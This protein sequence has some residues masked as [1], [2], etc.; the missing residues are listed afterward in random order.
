MNRRL[1]FFTLIS[2]IKIAIAQQLTGLVAVT[3]TFKINLDNHYKFSA[4]TLIPDSEV[5]HLRG[6]ILT[7]E[8]YSI[9]YSSNSFALSPK[10]SYSI[11]DTIIVHYQTVKLSLKKEYKIREAK[12]YYD[13]SRS[14][15]LFSLSQSKP[16][17]TESIFGAEIQKS[18]T[19]I[20]GFTIGSNK[21]LSLQ[22]G[23]RLQLSGKLTEDIELVA[24]IS[25]E[26]SP[27]QPEGNTETLDEL[28]K[29]FIQL[30]HKNF[31]AVF[32][33]YEIKKRSGE[34]GVVN[35]R[36]QGLSGSFQ[37]DDYNG[38]VAIASSKGKFNSQKF[39]GL[40]GVQ[41][42][43]RLSGL[44]GEREIIIIAGTEKVF[45]DGEEIKRGERNDYT[46]DY[47]I[48]E[49]TFTTN[50]LI[51]AASRIAVDFEYTDRR[52]IRNFF[53]AGSGGKFFNQKLKIDLQFVREGDDEDSPIDLILNDADKAILRD[54]GDDRM[55]ASRSGVALAPLDSI[56]VPRGVYERIDTLISGDSITFYKYNPG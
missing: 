17:S 48:A 9:S 23:L 45:I 10:L 46:I 26:N 49:I 51:T 16:F 50:K 30:N 38:F 40:D 31:S 6:R 8:E 37:L 47:A 12:F 55:N 41:G 15:S 36:L 13:F 52:F 32:G 24:A 56:G 29:V 5:L 14:D 21:D 22:S 11:F 20:R 3:D 28:D 2:T 44:N 39:N 54:A 53:S 43:Y 34:F 18:G 19:L 4:V 35:R 27:I 33:D 42:P 25:D 1:I 7:K